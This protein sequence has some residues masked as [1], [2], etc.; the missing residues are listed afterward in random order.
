[1]K[2]VMFISIFL[3]ALISFFAVN[4]CYAKTLVKYYKTTGDII[5]LNTVDEM[6]SPEILAD[7]FKSESTDVLL[8]E[9]SVDIS[10]QRVD[11]NKKKIIDI[12][13]KEL[14][15]TKKIQDEK[16]ATEKLIQDELR[17]QAIKSLKDKG[18]L[19]AN[20]KIVK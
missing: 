2:K 19:D 8:V 12:P 9:G 5:Q 7:R 15:D 13:K 4:V 17:A 10:T 3:I 14:E 16:I 11:L 20:G 6:P 18:V 1:M